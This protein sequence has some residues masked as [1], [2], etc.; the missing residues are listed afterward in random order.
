MKIPLASALLLPAL[1]AA[2]TTSAVEALLGGLPIVDEAGYQWTAA[3]PATGWQVGKLHWVPIGRDRGNAGRVQLAGDPYN[4]IAER[5]VNGMEAVIELA[6]RLELVNDGAAPM[7][8]SPR[9]AVQRYFN[10]PRLDL[11]PRTEDRDLRRSL[12][13][14]LR[15]VRRNLE[16]RADFDKRSREFAV[17]IR[18][19]GIGQTPE[20]VH[21]TLLSLGQTDKADKPYLIGV[22]GQGGSS[23]YFS[24]KY[25]VVISRRAGHALDGNRDGVGWSLIKKISPKNR[26]D[27]YYAYL[28]ASSDGRVPTVE[29]STA[30]ASQFSAGTL[31]RH[32]GYDFGRQ[33]SAVARTLYYALNHVLFNPVLPYD[34]YAG[35]DKPDP[36][37]GNAYRLTRQLVRFEREGAVVL[38]KPFQP[39]LVGERS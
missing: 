34:L 9:D 12:E 3:S 37:H 28:A 2:K 5:L 39:Q 15:E 7:P 18:D 8:L 24:S 11:I 22:F 26:R 30:N 19:F 13:E 6:R 33:G 14:R 27:P 4:P 16:L 35:K 23:T 20:R 10:L 31:F 29:L 1:L 17:E 36:M 38:D 21:E 32:V 25:S